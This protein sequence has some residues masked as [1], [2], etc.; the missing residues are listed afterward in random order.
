MRR[1]MA[2]RSICAATGTSAPDSWFHVL[3]IQAD[4][5]RGDQAGSG[6]GD[7]TVAGFQIGGHWQ[8]HGGADSCDGCEHQVLRDALA[9][10]IA[11]RECDSSA[12]GGDRGKAGQLKNARAGAIPCIR[13]HQN[14]R[15]AVQRTEQ[16]RFFVLRFHR[17]IIFERCHARAIGLAAK[18]SHAGAFLL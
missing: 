1:T 4:G 8:R 14:F 15:A 3:Q 11:E 12:G 5:A 18:S 13:Q 17:H 2:I 16:L 6:F 7:V 9:I 10:G